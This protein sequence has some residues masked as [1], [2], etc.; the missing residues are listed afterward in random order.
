M[1]FRRIA[2]RCHSFAT[3]VERDVEVEEVAIGQRQAHLR[4]I[5]RVERPN[6]NSAA[7]ELSD[8]DLLGAH[9]P[10]IGRA[11][12]RSIEIALRARELRG[13]LAEFGLSYL[14]RLFGII[15]PRL[16]RDALH[17]EAALAFDFG[18]GARKLALGSRDDGARGL[19]F[20]P[21][22]RWVDPKQRIAFLEKSAGHQPG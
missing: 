12:F 8:V 11:D 18:L 1:R 16:A 4:V 6:R 17:G 3:E 2:I 9:A 22:V 19:E 7:H 13:L 20:D 10:L 21:M 14:K 5:G 15:D